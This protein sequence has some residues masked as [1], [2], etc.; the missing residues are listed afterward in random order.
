MVVKANTILLS[1]FH[2]FLVSQSKVV[3]FLLIS[4]IYMTTISTSLLWIQ[5]IWIPL[6][7]TLFQIS[8]LLRPRTLL[9]LYR[10]QGCQPL[11]FFSLIRVDFFYFKTFLRVLIYRET[12]FLNII[13][14]K[15]IFFK[16]FYV[17]FSWQ[18][19][20]RTSNWPLNMDIQGIFSLILVWTDITF[21][22]QKQVS[23]NNFLFLI[24]VISTV[25][26]ACSCE[27]NPSSD[28]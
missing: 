9:R 5:H 25:P 15:F 21:L 26:K 6:L 23:K 13:C 19:W 18:P 11:I 20:H 12:L 2:F 7:W 17:L 28:A 8:S 3:L 27:Y 22:K 10:G 4:S 24:P 14:K 16:Y 1:F